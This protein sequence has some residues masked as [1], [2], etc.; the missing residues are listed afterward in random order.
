MI[1]GVSK[2]KI[3]FAPYFCNS[4]FPQIYWKK[5]VLLTI[6]QYIQRSKNRAQLAKHG[7]ACLT[8]SSPVHPFSIPENIRNSA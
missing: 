6:V 8:H 2:V 4:L 3:D 1:K 5:H 7:T